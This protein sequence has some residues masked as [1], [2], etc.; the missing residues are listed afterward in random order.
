MARRPPPKPATPAK[1]NPGAMTPEQVATALSRAGAAGATAEA[2]R[3]HVAAG[4]PANK[5]GTMNLVH[6]A[7][8]LVAKMARSP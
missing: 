6:Y 5:D 2:V 3:A 7:A 8:W 1:V 4:A